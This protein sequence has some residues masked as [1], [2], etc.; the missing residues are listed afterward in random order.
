MER[1]ETDLE[2][3]QSDYEKALA[4]NVNLIIGSKLQIKMAENVIKMLKSELNKFPEVAV[5]PMIPVAE[6]PKKAK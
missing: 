5:K 1:Y 2:L 4:D 6:T 3:R